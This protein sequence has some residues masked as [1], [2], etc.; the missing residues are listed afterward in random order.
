MPGQIKTMIDKIIAQ[1]G[2][3]NV[4]LTNVTKTKLILKGIDPDKF[5]SS[6]ADDPTIIGKLQTLARELNVSL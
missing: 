3:G 5:G 6:S 1:R 4:T 2:K